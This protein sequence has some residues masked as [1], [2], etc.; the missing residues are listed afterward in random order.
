MDQEQAS[1]AQVVLRRESGTLGDPRGG[2]SR[3]AETDAGQAGGKTGYVF[4]L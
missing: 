2:V 1:Q 4:R 3:A